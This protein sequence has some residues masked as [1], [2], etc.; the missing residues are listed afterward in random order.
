MSFGQGSKIHPTIHNVFGCYHFH[1]QRKTK[2]DTK[3]GSIETCNLPSRENEMALIFWSK[4]YYCNN[5]FHTLDISAMKRCSGEQWKHSRAGWCWMLVRAKCGRGWDSPGHWQSPSAGSGQLVR[6]H[7]GQ[8]PTAISSSSGP[9]TAAKPVVPKLRSEP[10]PPATTL[11][12]CRAHL[13]ITAAGVPSP[14][15]KPRWSPVQWVLTAGTV[16]YLLGG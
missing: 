11:C 2:P 14:G 10:T 13:P 12:K 5:S 15:T 9:S 16:A 1:G 8:W 6:C 3:N 7:A 4:L